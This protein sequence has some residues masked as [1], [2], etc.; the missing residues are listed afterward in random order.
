MILQAQGIR[1]AEL[2]RGTSTLEKRKEF[3][4]SVEWVTYMDSPWT[5]RHRDQLCKSI[6]AP[7][8]I[9]DIN[10]AL[11]ALTLHHVQRMLRQVSPSNIA[12]GSCFH[13]MYEWMESFADETNDSSL[14]S[15]PALDVDPLGEAIIRFGPHLRDVLTE[16]TVP[17]SI[18]TQDN[19]LS[20][21]YAE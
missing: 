12:E 15:E 6:V 9:A 5:L 20:R 18:L 8:S 11:E 16:K 7:A 3:C 2:P 13:H 21:I 1:L 10:K 14:I 19:L 17:F 4:R